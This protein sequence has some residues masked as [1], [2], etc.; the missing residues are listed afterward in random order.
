MP[1]Y[2][3]FSGSGLIANVEWSLTTNTA[4]PDFANNGSGVYQIFVNASGMLLGDLYTIKVYERTTNIAGDLALP[5][6]D[7]SLSGPVVPPVWVTPSLILGNLWDVTMVNS[8]V[9]GRNI[10]WSIRRAS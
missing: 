1:L 7:Q 5:V 4:G 3:Q 8:G 10:F 9:P 2:Q 6:F